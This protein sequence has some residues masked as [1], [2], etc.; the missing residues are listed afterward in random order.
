MYMYNGSNIKIDLVKYL[1]KYTVKRKVKK[2][3]F[4]MFLKKLSL[5]AKVDD[6]PAPKVEGKFQIERCVLLCVSGKVFWRRKF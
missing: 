4:S 5:D 6:L 3:T 1:E 2:N